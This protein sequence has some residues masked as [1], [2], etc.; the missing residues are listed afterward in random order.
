MFVTELKFSRLSFGD[1]ALTVAPL[2][3][4]VL[5]HELLAGT[6]ALSPSERRQVAI[7]PPIRTGN[8]NITN[9][10]PIRAHRQF[11]RA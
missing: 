4:E 1:P 10:H 2:F 11:A 7:H 5:E 6:T 3:L 9:N 8:S